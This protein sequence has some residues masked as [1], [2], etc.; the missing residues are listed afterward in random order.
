MTILH[1]AD[2]YLGM[3]TYGSINPATGLSDEVT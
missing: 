1:F 3:K 2:L